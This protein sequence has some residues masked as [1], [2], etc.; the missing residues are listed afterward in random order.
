MGKEIRDILK[1]KRTPVLGCLG[2]SWRLGVH[3]TLYISICVAY[4]LQTGLFGLKLRMWLQKLGWHSKI[5]LKRH[6]KIGI[7]NS[8]IMFHF[9]LGSVVSF[10]PSLCYIY[11]IQYICHVICT[12]YIYVYIYV[13][14]CQCIYIYYIVCRG[15]VFYPPLALLISL[16]RRWSWN[17]YK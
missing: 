16:R 3:K 15:D 10:S 13:Y 17:M 1:E 9:F 4:V 5:P 2:V 8:S 14:V 11:Y 12:L 7:I 6:A